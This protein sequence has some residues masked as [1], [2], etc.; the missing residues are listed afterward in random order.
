MTNS[1]LLF[2]DR[3]QNSAVARR[4]NWRRR[5]PKMWMLSYKVL[6]T[7]RVHYGAHALILDRATYVPYVGNAG[8]VVN[9][10]V[11]VFRSSPLKRA[12]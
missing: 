10:R 5:T 3:T 9:P 2:S 1:A 6:N 4:H 7:V 11:S 8:Q 12:K